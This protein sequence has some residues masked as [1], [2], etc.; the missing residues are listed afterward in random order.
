[1]ATYDD[2][3]AYFEEARGLRE[4]AKQSAQIPIVTGFTLDVHPL[5]ILLY[6]MHEGLIDQRLTNELYDWIRFIEYETP[7]SRWPW[8]AQWSHLINRVT[9]YQG[10]RKRDLHKRIPEWDNWVQRNE[11]RSKAERSP[12]IMTIVHRPL[13]SPLLDD[14]SEKD[15]DQELLKRLIEISAG[16]R[17]IVLVDE[18]PR[19]SFAFAAGDGIQTS[20][21][22]MG[23]LGGA[24][25]EVKSAKIFGVTCAH[26]ASTGDIVSDQHSIGLG[27]CVAHTPIVALAPGASADPLSYPPPGPYPNNGP[28]MNML[29][30]ALV[31]LSTA[32][33]MPSVGG[34]AS[35]LSTGQ[36]VTVTGAQTSVHCNLGSLAISYS[37]RAGH[38]DYCF[39]DT[40]ELIPQS[41]LPVGGR[42]SRLMA[43]CPTQGDSG[44]WVL[45]DD[46]SPIWAGML[47]GEDGTRGF[48]IRASWIKAWAEKSVGSAMMI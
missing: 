17:G 1:M 47:F 28:N 18:R 37:F 11:G 44:A 6:D 33:K 38:Q 21:G 14:E 2:L 39:R 35:Q 24:L 7:F 26:V 16:A 10:F 5:W 12:V 15:T 27:P 13:L 22:R 20:A 19:A 30:C 4:A 42:I 40:I 46:A 31:A 43:N 3:R 41:R 34:T 48:A 45:T 25:R 32:P 29:D 36:A 9:R 8:A 23:T